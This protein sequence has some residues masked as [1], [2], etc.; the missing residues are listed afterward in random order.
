MSLPQIKPNLEQHDVPAIVQHR[1]A[2]SLSLVA[3]C[4]GYGQQAPG[5][6]NSPGAPLVEAAKC[7]GYSFIH[8]IQKNLTENKKY[9]KFT[10]FKE[11]E[12]YHEPEHEAFTAL[13]KLPNSSTHFLLQF[14]LK[15]CT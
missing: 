11:K 8:H 7:S 10:A 5:T 9:S 13:L 6:S 2:P 4:S 1:Q 14:L 12:I 3:A 15:Y